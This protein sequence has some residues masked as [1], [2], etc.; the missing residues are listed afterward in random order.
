MT[1][2]LHANVLLLL[3]L[4]LLSRLNS[5]LEFWDAHQHMSFVHWEAEHTALE[6]L[7]LFGQS[8]EPGLRI[9]HGVLGAM[10]D[11]VKFD[12]IPLSK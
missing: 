1:N 9:R 11:D 5:A 2:L 7:E 12:K 8:L 10:K 3:S 6:L 4:K